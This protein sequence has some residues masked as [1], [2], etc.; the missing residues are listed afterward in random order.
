MARLEREANR[1]ADEW[2]RFDRVTNGALERSGAS[3]PP[4]ARRR[5][6]ESFVS[7][8]SAPGLAALRA[9]GLP[10]T[11]LRVDRLAPA[12]RP[13]LAKAFGQSLRACEEGHR[14]AY[15]EWWADPRMRR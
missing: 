12:A 11:R 2:R 8:A 9:A 10:R 15:Y 13:I 14:T 7:E 5:G 1:N 6:R 3:R 4:L